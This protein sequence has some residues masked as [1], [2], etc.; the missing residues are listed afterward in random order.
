DVG[1]RGDGKTS[2]H[3]HDRG[4]K[5]KGLVHQS[6][7]S[8]FALE[9]TLAFP[10]C[11]QAAGKAGAIATGVLATPRP[12]DIVVVIAAM[13]CGPGRSCSRRTVNAINPPA[14]A[15]CGHAS[16]H[17]AVDGSTPGTR[18]RRMWAPFEAPRFGGAIYA[19]DFDNR[20]RYRPSRSFKYMALMQPARW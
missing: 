11:Q 18:V 19:V 12:R 2:D 20:S 1:T 13:G 7:L 17:D 4:K 10:A 15:D 16:A 8:R 3:E 5:V 6:L 9:R 14:F